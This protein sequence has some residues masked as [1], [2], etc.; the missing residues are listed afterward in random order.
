M[1]LRLP[2][3]VFILGALALPHPATA[4]RVPSCATAGQTIAASTT[5]RV[6]ALRGATFACRYGATKRIRLGSDGECQG[7]FKPSKTR[8]AGRYVGWVST[9]CNLDASDDTATVADL[10]TARVKWTSVAATG[11]TATSSRDVTTFIRDFELAPN[12]SVAFVGVFDAGGDTLR[13]DSPL[14]VVQLRFLKRDSS[15]G[16]EVVDEGQEIVAGSL[17]LVGGGF[18]YRKSGQPIFVPRPTSGSTPRAAD[19]AAQQR[20]CAARGS[21][22]LAANGTSRVYVLP[23]E[24]V[25]ACRYAKG[26]RVLLGTVDDCIAGNVASRFRL[27]G[28]YVGY[29]SRECA[30]TDDT[31]TVVVKELNGA[32]T[33]HAA[34]A[35]GSAAT[36]LPGASVVSELVMTAHGTA[37]WIGVRDQPEVWVTSSGAGGGESRVDTGADIDR[38]SLA[39]SGAGFYYRKGATALFSP[40]Q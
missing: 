1:R 25:F 21:R 39:L 11:D 30:T 29:V 12:G 2:L 13:V 4:A 3:T 8:L 36:S 6:Y 32:R 19:G 17:A 33:V 40:L 31:D 24:D 15:E 26:R 14:D 5:A 22:T 18:Y 27:A 35:T 28:R 16:S 23:N 9:S 20:A 10:V 34:P 38:R 7:D 37:A